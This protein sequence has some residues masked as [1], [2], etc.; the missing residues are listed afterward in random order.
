M[1]E[2]AEQDN[3][4]KLYNNVA[5][6]YDLPDIET[7]KNDM[8]DEG[9]RSK[10]YNTVSKDYSLPDY[11]T[12]NSDMGF[13]KKAQTIPSTNGGNGSGELLQANPEFDKVPLRGNAPA[14]VQPTE[15][16]QPDP[17][18]SGIATGSNNNIF[19]PKSDIVDRYKNQD[20]ND[21]KNFQNTAQASTT[22]TNLAE[23]FN[24][25]LRDKSGKQY[26]SQAEP[27]LATEFL[28]QPQQD[29]FKVNQQL[30]EQEAQKKQGLREEVDPKL[31][32]QQQALKSQSQQEINNQLIDLAKQLNSNSKVIQ[33]KEGNETT[34]PLTW[35]E[36][37][38]ISKQAADLNNLKNGVFSDKPKEVEKATTQGLQSLEDTFPTL[39]KVLSSE[40]PNA[41]P[42]EKF[43]I[44]Y[45]VLA[46]KWQDLK[47]S[48]DARLGQAG[49]I[50]GGAIDA[51]LSPEQI[52]AKNRLGRQIGQN[53]PVIGGLFNDDG[54]NE[55]AKLYKTLKDNAPIALLNQSPDLS[56]D[57]LGTTF[58]KGIGKTLQGSSSTIQT[59]TEKAKN[60]KETAS[61]MGVKFDNQTVTD[62]V[63]EKSIP[64]IAKTIAEGMGS[65]VGVMPKFMLAGG[66]T[67]AAMTESGIADFAKGLTDAGGIFN[68][69]AGWV[70]SKGLPEA[71]KFKLSDQDA[72]AGL[73]M[74][75]GQD[76]ANSISSFVPNPLMRRVIGAALG[77]LTATAGM[78]F[79][80]DA[81][82]AA[83]TLA[84]DNDWQKYAKEHG[85][86]DMSEKAKNFLV[87]SAT[88]FPLGL[89]HTPEGKKILE[90][91]KEP[92]QEIVET[93]RRNN[94]L[95]DVK[96]FEQLLH[97]DEVIS[98][99]N[100]AVGA[101]QEARK[102]IEEK[103]VVPNLATTGNGQNL[104][105]EKPP[106]LSD[107]HNKILQMPL[108][109]VVNTANE[110]IGKQKQQEKDIL[111]DD[112]DKYKTLE[113]ISERNPTATYNKS[114]EEIAQADKEFK[115]LNT[116]L[117]DGLGK[118]PSTHEDMLDAEEWRPIRNTA[119]RYSDEKM[120]NEDDEDLFSSV[121]TQLV[122]GNFLKEPEGGIIMR[123]S[124]NELLKRGH[125]IESIFKEAIKGRI[126]DFGENPNDVLEVAK[127][128]LKKFA[129][130]LPKEEVKSGIPINSLPAEHGA[131]ADK[132]AQDLGF[133]NAT[134]LVNAV[135]KNEGTDYQSHTEIPQAEI[136]KAVERKAMNNFDFSTLDNIG[137]DIQEPTID[138]QRE[139]EYQKSTFDKKWASNYKEAKRK[140]I[141]SY[142]LA[143]AEKE[144]WKSK[145]YKSSGGKTVF[146]GDEIG[147]NN[148]SVDYLNN[149]K[150]ELG[151]KHAESD[152]KSAIS[153]LR[154]LGF[155]ESEV[156]DVIEQKANPP[157]TEDITQETSKLKTV[158]D[159]PLSKINANTDAFQ[160]R[161]TE[162]SR[163]TVDN[164]KDAVKSGTFDMKDLD[165]IKLWKD[166]KDSKLYIV[167]GH[168]RTQAFKE[169]A[170]EGHKG[171]DKIPAEVY[172]GIS[173]EEAIKKAEASNTLST[174][175]LPSERAKTY[176][177][178][179]E[180]GKTSAE[181]QK[182]AQK[183]EGKNASTVIAYSHLKP[184]GKTM[185]SLKA[186]ESSGES[187]DAGSMKV[188]A[189]W[190][191]DAR[192][193][194]P[195]LTD[196]HENEMFKYLSEDGKFKN[197][198]TQSEFTDRIAQIVGKQDLIDGGFN[199]EK[200]LNLN[201][202]ISKSSIELEHDIRIR[203]AD[204]KLK[205]AQ[206][207]LKKKVRDL[208]SKGIKGAQHSELLKPY[209]G[210]VTIAT[211]DLIALKNKTGEVKNAA[212]QQL[213]I[214]DAISDLK[215]K[216]EVTDGS[217]EREI[218][219]DGGVSETA[220][221]SEKP[222]A[223]NE[224]AQSGEA[225][226]AEPAKEVKPIIRELADANK[227]RII[228]ASMPKIEAK[229]PAGDV[230][231]TPPE[232][233]SENSLNN[234]NNGQETKADGEKETLL[235]KEVPE[236]V[237][238]VEP[239]LSKR[240]KIEK[241]LEAA[242]EAFRNSIKGKLN[243]GLDPEAFANLVKVAYHSIRLGLH[244]AGEFIASFKKDFGDEVSDEDLAKA[245]ESALND[246][247][248]AD[249]TIGLTQ[250]EINDK[251]KSQGKTE[252][253]KAIAQSHP[254][255]YEKAQKFR[256][257]NNMR[258][259]VADLVNQE[260]PKVTKSQLA[261]IHFEMLDTDKE[262]RKINKQLEGTPENPES[263]SVRRAYL[264][265]YQ[266]DLDKA[267]FKSGS[268]WGG[269]GAVRQL[270]I[271]NELNLTRLLRQATE[272]N[273]GKPLSEEQKAFF[274]S[275]IDKIKDL[276][277]KLNEREAA[278]KS[279]EQELSKKQT[280]AEKTKSDR[281]EERIK[282]K[283][284]PKDWGKENKV[285]T[286]GAYE[287][288]KEA[289]KGKLFS[290]PI[291]PEMITIAGYHIEAGARKFKD[292]TE[293][294]IREFG[295]D[296]KPHLKDLYNA[297]KE[298]LGESGEDKRL[299]RYKKNLSTRL[300]KLREQNATG[301]VEPVKKSP[302]PID[303]EVLKLK[304]AIEKEKDAILKKREDIRK[305]NRTGLQKVADAL[306]SWHRF[307][308][309]S[310]VSIAAKLTSAALQ[311]LAT[312]L[313]EEGVGAGL[314]K[315]PGL[316]RIAA[317][318][319]LEGG[320][321]AQSIAKLISTPFK[322]QTLR[323]ALEVAKTGKGMIEHLYGKKDNLSKEF[324]NMIGQIHAA[325][326][327]PIKNAAFEFSYQKR[328]AKAIDKGFDVSDPAL[329][330]VI[331]MKSYEDA[332][333]AIF[334]QSNIITEQYQS[335][336]K[337]AENKGHAG[338]ATLAKF[339][340]PIIKVPTNFANE[341]LT[342]TGGG[343]VKG[344]IQAAT[345][346][347]KGIETLKPEEADAIMRNLK[348]GSIGMAAML[349]G[350]F[351]AANV[352]GYYVEGEKRKE[353][354]LK[355]N[356]LELFGVKIPHVL[357]HSPFVYAVQFGATVRRTLDTYGEKNKAHGFLHGVANA[358]LGAISNVPFLNEPT[359]IKEA[360][361]SDEKAAAW[362]ADILRSLFIPA[363]GDVSTIAKMR[364]TDENGKEIKRKPDGFTDE[365]KA[366]IPGLREQVP[367]KP[368][369]P[370]NFPATNDEIT[371]YNK[372]RRELVKEYTEQYISP[373]WSEE[374]KAK[375]LK[376]IHANATKQAK[377][378][379][380]GD[381][382]KKPEEN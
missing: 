238:P 363:S 72:S 43:N 158:I 307:G 143:K 101:N 362:S 301:N 185:Q 272:D 270:L 192:K 92:I 345:A 109:D 152:M 106:K 302:P 135:N 276:Q 14:Q 292:F 45:H 225:K 116:K 151:I 150:R 8:Q 113:A 1:A 335:L 352:G 201:H 231:P 104:S 198:R 146:V 172:E 196:S 153:D 147:G 52:A 312:T 155:T 11:E 70:L 117:Q 177:K 330:S 364:D 162:F 48:N 134:H 382:A 85:Y 122:N 316:R 3:L 380:F 213:S 82:G 246:M 223:E 128:N 257:T 140:I 18:K 77:S 66:L 55:E 215:Q 237:S 40:Y 170:K 137:N 193:R 88:F 358:E 282:K 366:N 299:E 64:T 99:E 278:V 103:T 347:A 268:E 332:N 199:P 326:K 129:E 293:S 30:A 306:V 298:K 344:S 271:D 372:T 167:S 148:Y 338:V 310:N 264:E 337:M 42:Q 207:E 93:A 374:K 258:D 139:E 325:L 256:D 105:K 97:P 12:F 226:P 220:K 165:A 87:N 309:L 16:P 319:D 261:A 333:R 315:I 173:K 127:D 209:Q 133:D 361:Q 13:K 78:D 83:K 161:D 346:F 118:I 10:F 25:S 243:T 318:S 212:K 303:S 119:K 242:K 20:L 218:Q 241:D 323:E 169:L 4:T 222:S 348:K 123:Q 202:S 19:A 81:L 182:E 340:L 57:A 74:A 62:L 7:F 289:M 174:K 232:S 300:E 304:Y 336:I 297:V 375:E 234:K 102:P 200:P 214:F 157:K 65:M 211:R 208:D 273:N 187:K 41:T 245:H 277:D 6:D 49:D 239:K 124:L 308:V 63:N 228:I 367:I 262:L 291:T 112:Y 176:R 357:L 73:G 360:S 252:L 311:R 229:E 368:D 251:R 263:L 219:S 60:I 61:S 27:Q 287:K 179:R 96:S 136:D 95:E 29:L 373:E 295:K 314:S 34:I 355:P 381:R 313:G 329:Q 58:L 24:P 281:E 154:R 145:N 317:K 46:K 125:D 224:T 114:P 233:V 259:F 195:Q 322:K 9:K 376:V 369:T 39:D 371:E 90:E 142:N 204:R 189:K 132:Q 2:V 248:K 28:D 98:R 26:R 51:V 163:D 274:K 126:K 32:S 38:D 164:I 54:L 120:A 107:L 244:D 76:L 365:L 86:D 378:K 130:K 115:E 288:A 47:Q 240:E 75:A 296:I 349:L 354:D 341:T 194:F 166:P 159:V 206:E 285:F 342:Y 379:I 35:E 260:E 71:V 121:G 267:V 230:T 91:N 339:L 84:T 217:I 138:E 79:S 216:G 178:M 188:I 359:R 269:E 280:E 290:T 305:S 334:M 175:E 279:R 327:N 156:N 321:N 59:D 351:G 110:Q 284:V 100:G 184:E 80:G 350:A 186:F 255:I 141:E 197:I 343:L 56:N 210:A 249:G 266:N 227:G 171:F 205:D 265:D 254:E 31:Y 149:K 203:D 44:G 370:L 5:K 131:E 183:A 50:S 69:A 275:Q 324:S 181:I 286:Q 221:S 108:E 23:A 253:E 320:I 68:K 94:N 160:N 89:L 247:S 168:S 377:Y 111:G 22:P 235:N 36:R 144:K 190:I 331:A 191:G 67:D 294:M 37:K 353:D 283:Q 17:L 250:E 356:D 328:L 33:D 236:P 21:V 53:I 15:Q 180:Q